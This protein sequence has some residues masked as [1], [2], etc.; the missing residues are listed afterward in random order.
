MLTGNIGKRGAGAYTWA[1]NYK[2]ALFQASPWSGPGAGTYTH[3]DPFHP[4]GFERHFSRDA[5]VRNR[6]VPAD[7]AFDEISHRMIE[8]FLFRDRAL[9]DQDLDMTMIPGAL[10]HLA[11]AYVIDPAVTDVAPPGTVLLYETDSASRPRPKIHGEIGTDIDDFVVRPGHGHVQK[12]LRIEQRQVGRHKQILH[13]LKTD[14][15]GLGA[16]LVTTHAV[17]HEHDPGLVRDDYS[18]PVLVVLPV[19]QC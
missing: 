15:R 9:L 16:V 17:K 6:C 14:F 4:V 2:G 12:A 19:P 5:H 7:T 1:G 3:E 10:E 18:R 8:R 11:L 13:D